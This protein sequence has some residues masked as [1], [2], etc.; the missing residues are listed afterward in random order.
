[1]NYLAHLALSYPEPDLIGGNYLFDLV[2]PAEAKELHPYF[3]RGVRLHKWIDH[4]SNQDPHLREMNR[5]F[6]PV[7]H[8]YA[9]VASDIICDHLLFLSWQNHFHI[10]FKGFAE[11]NYAILLESTRWMPQRIST[12]CVRMVEHRW[13]SQYESIEGVRQVLSRT[14]LKTQ[15]PVDLLQVI[16]VVEEHLQHFQDLF[17]RFFQQCLAER[18]QW[19]SLQNERTG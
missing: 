6:H 16:P 9:P 1:M 3:E 12:I 11:D 5:Y 2:T 17:D 15:F 10:P 13:L 4:Y 7:V 14:N 19:I 8:K 18:N